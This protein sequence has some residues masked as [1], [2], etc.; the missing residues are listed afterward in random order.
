M[1]L[2]DARLLP[3]RR[4]MALR[5]FIG[6]IRGGSSGNAASLESRHVLHYFNVD[7]GAVKLAIVKGMHENIE[8]RP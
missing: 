4:Q 3:P 8:T 2:L 1:V 6:A 7:T 5:L